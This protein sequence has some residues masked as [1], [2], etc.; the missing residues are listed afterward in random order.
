MEIL[1]IGDFK[2][3]NGPSMVDINLN[4]YFPKDIVVFHQIQKKIELNLLKKIINCKI[5]VVSG[6]SFLGAFSFILGKLFSKKNCL[7]MHGTLKLERKFRFVPRYRYYI[8]LFSIFCATK[9]IAV[10]KKFSKDLKDLY[11]RKKN[12]IDYVNNGVEV[13]KKSNL[14]KVKGKVLTVGG[15]R[16]EK[17][18]LTICKALDKL[19][20]I[21]IELLVAGEDGVDTEEIK[22]YSFVN[23][24]GFIEHIQLTELM[25]KSELFIQNSAYEP[26][27]MAPLEALNYNC[28]LLLSENVSSKELLNIRSSNIIHD[29]KNIDEIASKIEICLLNENDTF[30]KPNID[31]SWSKKSTQYLKSIRNIG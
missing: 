25:K 3:K 13:K 12:N 6:I 8:E 16:K 27:G 10:S 28:K 11:P 24:L 5:I 4:K 30:F 18:I 21:D 22:K 9:I 7:I 26:F 2:K 1:Y 20:D 17:G 15:G 29:Y 19:K 23:Y 31:L 14:S